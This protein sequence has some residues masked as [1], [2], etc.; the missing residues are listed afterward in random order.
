MVEQVVGS[1]LSTVASKFIG[2]LFGG[3]EKQEIAAAAPRAIT[4]S[5]P[6]EAPVRGGQASRTAQKI[7]IQR[8]RKRGG[9][10]ETIKTLAGSQFGGGG[11]LG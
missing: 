3:D 10:E 6:P 7:A 5:E 4:P 9:R 1:V 8:A 11:T 2:K